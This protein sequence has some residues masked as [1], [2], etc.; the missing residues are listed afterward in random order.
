MNYVRKLGFEE[1]PDYDFLRELFS[2]VL[3][4]LNEPEDG[5]FDWMLLNGGKGWEANNVGPRKSRIFGW[6]ANKRNKSPQHSG[7]SA[8][9]PH[10]ETRRE[11]D[12]GRRSRQVHDGTTPNQLVLSPAPI[13]HKNSR[14]TPAGDRGVNTR[15][16]GSV[17]PL[18]PNSRRGSQQ[19]RDISG[20]TSAALTAPPH[21]Y[22]TAP[23][24]TG[25]R[26][27]TT[28]NTYGRHSPNAPHLHANGNGHL[29][30]SESFL[31]GQAQAG[32]NG[33]GEGMANPGQREMGGQGQ[34]RGMGMYDR[35]QMQRVGEQDEDG[36]HHRP[37]GF[38]SILCCRG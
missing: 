3:K 10:R 6:L 31:Y 27:A 32:K 30:G 13:H 23:S 34:V 5:V 29:N 38:F 28:P 24:P 4:T 8:P 35:D 14:R 21:P 25:Y 37:R 11:R 15:D 36:G 7:S 17:Q 33:S 26:A 22:A 1:T 20:M 18:A 2:K 16:L 9:T 19:Q 12:H